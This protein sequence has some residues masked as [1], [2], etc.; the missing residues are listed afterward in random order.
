MAPGEQG[1][2]EFDEDSCRK[3]A[4]KKNEKFFVSEAIL[5]WPNAGAHNS[6][7]QEAAKTLQNEFVEAWRACRA[8]E[9]I[10]L[11]YMAVSSALI[12]I[13]SRNLAHPLRLVMTQ[14]VVSLM[15]LA[16]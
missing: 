1:E 3:G 11:G 7:A 5:T 10:A 15:V 4:M 16:L 2:I 8:F 14:V 12:A 6:F 13:F 9:W